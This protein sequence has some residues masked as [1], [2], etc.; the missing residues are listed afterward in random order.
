MAF[1]FAEVFGLFVGLVGGPEEAFGAAVAGL[2]FS[3]SF[4]LPLGMGNRNMVTL[5]SVLS[6]F[7]FISMG[8]LPRAS[9][10]TES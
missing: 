7:N 6:S 10:W 4:A 1:A 8:K 5:G 2:A 3:G 9:G